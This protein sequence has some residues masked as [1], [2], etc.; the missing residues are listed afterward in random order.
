MT[1][2]S[3]SLLSRISGSVDGIIHIG[4]GCDAS[5]QDYAALQP[6]KITLVE[7]DPEACAILAERF[8]G[9]SRVHLV[10]ALV[11]PQAANAAFHRF[12]LPRFNGPFGL[13]RLKN[14]YPRITEMKALGLR[15]R[16]LLDILSG[17]GADFQGPQLLILNI[18]GQEASVLSSLPPHFL[19]NFEWVLVNGSAQVWQEGSQVVQTTLDFLQRLFFEVVETSPED[20]E[21]PSILLRRDQVKSGLQK[22]L[23]SCALELV[24]KGTEIH[25]RSER[26]KELETQNATLHT[27]RD[28]LASERDALSTS[29]AES[30]AELEKRA[31]LLVEK[32]TEIHQRSERNKELETQNA[33][34]HTERDSLATA[35]DALQ[36]ERSTLDSR[37]S[38]L[39]AEREALSTELT[40]KTTLLDVLT[41][42][43]VAQDEQMEKMLQEKQALVHDCAAHSAR[44]AD[45]EKENADLRAHTKFI[46]EEFG[47]AEGQLELI[48]DIFL[49]E[50][51]R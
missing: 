32:G 12:S 27:E 21:W 43:R 23:E 34:L 18:P 15:S 11:G 10:E 7:A 1:Q 35:R 8:Q 13:G 19:D 28:S 44:I 51:L 41:K 25:R 29:L 48:K 45:L 31:S 42:G 39:A 30:K 26:N 3:S 14:M 37:L 16:P 50:A 9:D 17:M 4:A 2:I 22:E 33:T 20:P 24:E 6:R 36:A 46:N 47:K 38:T 40:A 49:R 5:L